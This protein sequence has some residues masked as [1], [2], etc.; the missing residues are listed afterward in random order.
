MCRTTEHSQCNLGGCISLLLSWAYHHILLPRPNGFDT[1]RFCLVERWVEYHPDNARGEYRLSH[2]RHTL[3][4]I[5]IFNKPYVDLHLQGVV[6]PGIAE[7]EALVV[8]VCPLLCFAI[9]EWH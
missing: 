2:Y 8:V 1:R 9:I 4:G 3:N 7:A 6:P 5:D